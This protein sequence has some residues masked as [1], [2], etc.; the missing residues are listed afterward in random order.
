MNTVYLGTP[1]PPPRHPEKL[2]NLGNPLR[3][4]KPVGGTNIEQHRQRQFHTYNCSLP[5]E[6]IAARQRIAPPLQRTR[7]SFTLDARDIIPFTGF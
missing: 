5:Y 7:R 4:N 1:P 2:A 6:V 3:P